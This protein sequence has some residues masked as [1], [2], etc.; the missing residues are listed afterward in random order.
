MYQN[1]VEENVKG[2]ETLGWR[3]TK[4]QEYSCLVV[5]KEVCDSKGNPVYQERVFVGEDMT[6]ERFATLDRLH[7]QVFENK[8]LK[9]I[10]PA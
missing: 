1:R 7:V 10:E 3:R 4:D 2:F 8:L 9:R 5:F 6:P